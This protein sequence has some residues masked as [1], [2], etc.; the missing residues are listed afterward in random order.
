MNTTIRYKNYHEHKIDTYVSESVME[1]A[2]KLCIDVGLPSNIQIFD[3]N[4]IE[5]VE[6]R[7]FSELTEVLKI[8]KK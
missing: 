7:T 4:G 2:K 6:C 5:R 8:L 1:T 3:G